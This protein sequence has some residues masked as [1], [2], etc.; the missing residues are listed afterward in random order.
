MAPAE[1]LLLDAGFETTDQFL[2]IG[3][4]VQIGMA[5]IVI[6]KEAPGTLEQMRSQTDE[7]LGELP[8]G[9]RDYVR[10][11]QAFREREWEWFSENLARFQ[12]ASGG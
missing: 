6:D 3:D 1:G 7:N 10:V 5:M 4:R 9:M 11:I 2:R 8:E 12:R